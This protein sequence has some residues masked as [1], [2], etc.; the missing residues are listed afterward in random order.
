MA[1]TDADIEGPGAPLRQ[2][3]VWQYIAIAP[4]WVAAAC[5]FVMMAMTF[6]DVILRSAFD[7]PLEYATELTRVFMAVIVFASLPM[8]SWKGQHI[9]VDLMDPIFPRSLTRIRDVLIDLIAG[10]ALIVTANR[11]FEIAERSRSRGLVTEYMGMPQ[12]YVGWFIAAFTAITAIVLLIRGLARIF[13]PS[14]VP[15]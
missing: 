14:K 3:N 7:N 2:D 11:V 13:F 6:L 9:V 15:V 12:H 5:L 10:G 1:E 8:V 4:T